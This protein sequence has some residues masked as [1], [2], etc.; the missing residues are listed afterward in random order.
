MR[1][2]VKSP[3]HMAL[4]EGGGEVEIDAIISFTV[5]PGREATREEPAEAPEVE[6]VKF[7]LASVGAVFADAPDWMV[8]RFE[9]DDSFNDWL[10]SEAADRDEYERDRAAEAR[11]KQKEASHV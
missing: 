5:S 11:A 1:Y 9:C 2:T 7:Q 10:I 6:I 8:R 4:W 3:L